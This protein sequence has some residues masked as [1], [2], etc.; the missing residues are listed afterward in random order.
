MKTDLTYIAEAKADA[1]K[2]ADFLRLTGVSREAYLA[3]AEH[4]IG[5]LTRIL[6]EA[7]VFHRMV[8]QIGGKDTV[9]YCG[10]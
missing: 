6:R 1:E 7:K 8:I 5:V 2:S 9:V 10:P 3:G 4:G